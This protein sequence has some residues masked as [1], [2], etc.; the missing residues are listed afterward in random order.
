[1]LKQVYEGDLEESF[2]FINLKQ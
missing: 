1:M 2:D